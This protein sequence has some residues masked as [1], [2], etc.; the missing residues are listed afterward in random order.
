MRDK[1]ELFKEEVYKENKSES[2]LENWLE[3]MEKWDGFK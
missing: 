2:R 1:N 3:K